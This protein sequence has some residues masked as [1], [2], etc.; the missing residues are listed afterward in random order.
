MNTF[1]FIGHIFSWTVFIYFA[2][3]TLYLFVIALCG[4]LIKGKKFGIQNDKFQIAILIPC[5]R[6][7]N[8]ILGYGA[9]G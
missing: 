9:T 5:L 6:E 7:D 8:I 3:N 1:Y 4:L 2:A